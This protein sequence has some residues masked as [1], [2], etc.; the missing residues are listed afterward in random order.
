VAEIVHRALG[1]H[2]LDERRTIMPGPRIALRVAYLLLPAGVSDFQAAFDD[3]R[4]T[5]PELR[6]LLSGPWPPYSFVT[7][8]A[9]DGAAQGTGG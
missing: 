3:A 9:Q 4:R 1:P 2:A 8:E 5:Q 7:V 6:F